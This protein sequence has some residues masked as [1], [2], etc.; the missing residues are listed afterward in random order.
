MKEVDILRLS[1]GTHTPSAVPLPYGGSPHVGSGHGRPE[2][3]KVIAGIQLMVDALVGLPQLLLD[4]ALAR[5]ASTSRWPNPAGQLPEFGGGPSNIQR[6]LGLVGPLD[7]EKSVET[8]RG[9]EQR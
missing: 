5:I 3:G 1:P 8:E 6:L 4:H 7:R 2:G 9:G